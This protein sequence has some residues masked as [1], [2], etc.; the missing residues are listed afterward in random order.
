VLI[1]RSARRQPRAAELEGLRR[2]FAL[3]QDLQLSGV[4]SVY[5]LLRSEG[6]LWLVL[7][8][9]G[10][11]PLAS[12]LASGPIDLPIFFHL[13]I[14]LCS[15]L[16]GLHRR[17]VIHRNIHPG[18]ILV[19]AETRE[20][21]LGDFDL[22]SRGSVEA[23]APAPASLPHG[24]LAYMSPEQTG[25]MNRATDYRSDF[26]SLGVTFYELLTGVRPFRSADALEL[27]HAH[28]AR[29]PAPP[30]E[31]QPS[32]PETVSRIVMKLL[33]KTA[34]ARYQ[35]AEGLK[36]D[37]EVCAREWSA[38]RAVTPFP[39][40]ANDVSDR[41]LIPQHL[42]G[43]DREVEE[44]TTA[45]GRACEGPPSLMLVAGYSGIGK[46]SLIQELSR[47][48]VR[49]RGYF[50]SG[51]FDQVVRNIPFGALIQ[52]FRG[53]V[54]QLLTES[55]ERLALWRA[56]LEDALGENGGVL[57]EVIPEIE[58]IIGKQPPVP[59]LAA[60]ET[61]NRFRLAFQN[62]VGALAGK[63]HPLV[64]FLDDL[65]WAD[66]A[67]LALLQP[68]LTS[69]DIR[70]LFVLGAYRDNEVDL[71]HLL[72]R[73][74][75]ALEGSGARVGRIVLGPL[76]LSDLT[77]LASDCLHRDDAEIEA[78]A[79]LV[80]AKTEGNPFFVRQFLQTLWQEGL[81]KFDHDR[82]RWT[83]RIDD[84]A[85]A[86]M[87]DNVI[88]LMSRRIQRLS[89]TTQHLFTLAA[90]A[91]NPFDVR[92]LAIIS[93]QS[94]DET[95]RG[96]REALDAG[97]L[98]PV[99]SYEA[100]P[101]SEEDGAGAARYAF[102][103]DRVQQAAYA[104]LP[105][106]SRQGLHLEVGRLLLERWDRAAAE[107]NV[108]EIVSHLNLGRDLISDDAER[109]SLACLNLTAGLR[110]KASTAYQ[111]ALGH[112]KAGLDL[113][114]ESLWSSDYDLMFALQREAGEGEYLCGQFDEA[115]RRFGEL[116]ARAQTR[117]DKA[118]V[119]DLRLLQYENMSRYAEA[120]EI[121]LE[122][123]RLFGVSFP[124]DEEG[125]RAALEA[126]IHTIEVLLGGR[127]IESLV[128]LPVM[129]DLETRMVLRLLTDMWAPAYIWGDSPL[130]ALVSARIVRLSI[131]RGNTEDSAYGYVTHAI[132]VGPLRGEYQAAYEWGTLALLVNDRFADQRRRARIHQQFNA[133]VTLWRRPLAT[134]IPHAQE[135]C[136]SGL[137]TG[138]F[139]Y[140][141][142]GAFTETWPA[143]LTSKDL[144]RFVGDYV[145]TLAL[146][147]RIRTT[148][149]AAAHNVMLNWARALQARTESPLS[150]SGASFEE[151]SFTTAYGDNPFF[152]TV[153][154]VAKLHLSLLLED[155]PGALEA[156][157]RARQLGPWG[158]GTIWPVL[159]EFWGALARSW[160]PD[161]PSDEA[162]PARRDQLVSARNAVAPLA[163]SCPENFRCFWL[164]LD[165]EV[166]RAD[167]RSDE[168]LA[169]YE[170]AIRYGQRT[171]SLQ[172]EALANEL[173][174]SLWRHRGNERVAAVYLG[175]ARRCYAEWGAVAKVR[176]LDVRYP[177]LAKTE[178]DLAAPSLDVGTVTKAAHALASEI[179][180]E[181]LLRKLM[182]IALENAGA[183]RGF[184]LR[185]QPEGLVIQAEG[186][187]SAE[188]V[189]VPGA[190]PLHSKPGL[191][192]AVVQYVRKTGESVV[193]ADA[194][195][196]R[197][198]ASDPYIRSMLPKSILC[199]RV[200][201]QGKLGGLL[202]LENNLTTGAFTADRIE[203][204]DVLS[205]QAAIALE[206]ARLYDEMKREA[207]RRRA[208][209]ETLRSI[210]QGTA[211]IGSDFFPSLVK[212]L[213]SALEVRHAFV[214]ACERG[215]PGRVRTLAFWKGGSFAEN[216]KYDA[217][218]TP[219]Q[220]VLAGEVRHHAENVQGLFPGDRDL[221]ELRAES[222]VGVPIYD[223]A[224]KVIGH[225]VVLDDKP[226]P[227]ASR[228]VAILKT[229]SARAG[230]EMQRLEAEEGLRAA[231]VEVEG[232]KN[233]LHVEN[234]YL[235]E[236]IRKEHN[237]EEM[238]GGTPALLET[239]RRV[240]QVARTDSTVLI[241]GET[242]TGKELIARAVHNRS[243]RKDRPLVKVNCGAIAAG[244][245]ES[246]LFGHVK[247]AFTGALQKRIGRF[248]VADGGTIFLDEVGELP[249]DTQVK[250]LRVLQEQEFE[251]VGSSHTVRV[252]V[253]V[254]AATN[255]DLEEAQRSGRFRA[256]LL[257]RLNVFPLRVP[258]LRERRAD[259]PL[260]VGFFVA[261]LAKK[262]GKP[263]E[264]FSRQDVERLMNYPWP[265]NIRE[266]EN[267]VERA[268]IVARGPRLEL[269]RELFGTPEPRPG[270]NGPQ[271]IEEVERD[272]IVRVLGTTR[273]V[274]E[275]P[276]GAAR[277]LGLNP[278]TLRS[279][280]KK[281]GIEPRSHD[282]S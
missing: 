75:A 29:T 87:T 166:K 278:N 114:P 41:F 116:L 134:C 43:R 146:L 120:A 131:E 96:L 273:G 207:A 58:L 115:E 261:G 167:E 150:L 23:H 215:S 275:G 165:A 187:V 104:R 246:E 26:Y 280:M 137:R 6:N 202:Y 227:D 128:D 249:L 71:S 9:R 44:L 209:E 172:N 184:F 90:C 163:D 222:Y 92:T 20:L 256:D 176:Q 33:E 141:G 263:L 35:S 25:R 121:G 126:E 223:A 259:I 21:C 119:H 183:E 247:G 211:V 220:G 101:E 156:A 123:L 192:H 32:L 190:M 236:E 235:Q 91:G 142:Y 10:G 203:V 270:G 55:E 135:A 68:L 204:L 47:P 272:H 265:G 157:R 133:H 185:E 171:D 112:F 264:G 82:R 7:E 79:R 65:Q 160:A 85:G 241:S 144:D 77:R 262:L 110:A 4:P 197:R 95:V 28:I 213:A 169:T 34:E 84:I 178:K 80:V 59:P 117:L 170:E 76:G 195:S 168:A 70:S 191:S 51:K 100:A 196:D 73:T 248:E 103:H 206:N 274:V 109:L 214:A 106:E 233:R 174:G 212:H 276:R 221:A 153:F 74:T 19:H 72:T 2:E 232:L 189:N 228:S 279:R 130:V 139:T 125:K 45:F 210:V 225:L 49:Q 22:A 12:L 155:Y 267:V 54:Q 152:M 97:L 266:L 182:R 8:D 281:L 253:R 39:L 24:A 16:A 151:G 83:F 251:P 216:F 240:E 231:L 181:E 86:P 63:E 18:S 62:F 40:A 224:A 173:C 179:V 113:V 37:L 254:I 243:T 89:A 98:Q 56:Q 159:L 219:C 15:I 258:S 201:H 27:I 94:P 111:G 257:Y 69:P 136:R 108:F 88:D 180:L 164:L 282:I 53:L 60:A 186:T 148:G 162:G 269:D 93:R 1:K 138:D 194:V 250:L 252:D 242:G 67:S 238:V 143:F 61:Q 78:L 48:I 13:A 118:Q 218:S 122:G 198:F 38:R 42:Y 237:F 234:V 226:M 81:L 147:R 140:A 52:A 50:I 193:I 229:F 102:L 30:A 268:A 205:T 149:L 188:G 277:L 132:S 64:L 11:A 5:E 154:Y 199:V 57:T 161:D 255:R 175:E 244:L 3:L 245:V 208:A 127:S 200:V 217:E 158:R 239:L 36:A 271:T 66:A 145:P 230:A 99:A 177:W 124:E 129:E 17:D 105:E 260:L 107:E 14:Q 46:T 31:L